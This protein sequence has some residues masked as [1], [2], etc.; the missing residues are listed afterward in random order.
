MLARILS[1]VL[2][3]LGATT[4][5]AAPP[6]PAANPKVIAFA[7]NNMTKQ[8][9]DGE[10]AA[11]A[12]EALKAAGAKP[13][14]SWKDS[15]NDGDYVWGELVYGLKIQDGIRTEDTAIGTAPQ[16]GDVIQYRNAEFAG[17]TANGGK[18]TQKMPHHTAIVLSVK[19]NGKTIVVLEQNSGGRK[20]VG[21]GTIRLGD[22]QSGWLKVYRPVKD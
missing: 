4:G 2:F 9:G 16:A 5:L 3:L 1:G 10:C 12:V 21:E 20:T 7:K 18:Y 14:R 6:E 13:F 11:L 15:P 8:V 22:L 17:K 19:D